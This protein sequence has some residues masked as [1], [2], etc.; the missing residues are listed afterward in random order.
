MSPSIGTAQVQKSGISLDTFDTIKLY[1]DYTVPEPVTSVEDA[2]SRLGHDHAKLLAV[3]SDGLKAAIQNEA[4]TATDG[5][6]QLGD[7]DAKE[8][9]DGQLA[10][11]EDVNP[12]VLMFAKLSFGYDEAKT[13][14]ERK[15]AKTSAFEYVKSD[16]KIVASL[17][18]KASARAA[19]AE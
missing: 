11:S 1:R 18:K 9:F 10:D 5:W 19:K 4:R 6:Y 17:Q 2:L 15:A 12:V 13:P 7:G 3:I 16:P 8:P 14:E